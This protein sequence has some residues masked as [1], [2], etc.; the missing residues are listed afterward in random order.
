MAWY[1]FLIRLPTYRAF[2][3]SS[4]QVG[5]KNKKS[6]KCNVHFENF[7]EMNDFTENF[8][9]LNFP[10]VFLPPRSATSSSQTALM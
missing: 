2:Q 6:L 10:R 9:L 1:G 7:R 5:L 4:R 3:L 8:E